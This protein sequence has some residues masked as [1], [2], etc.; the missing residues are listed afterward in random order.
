M[1]RCPE[2]IRCS[3]EGNGLFWQRQCGA[4]D[5]TGTGEQKVMNV[6][7]LKQIN[8]RRM[9]KVPAFW[10]T[11]MLLLAGWGIHTQLRAEDE[12]LKLSGTWNILL[13]G[14]DRRSDNWNGNSDTMILI[15]TNHDVQKIFMVSFMRDLYANIPGYGAQ[16]LTNAYA[17]GGSSLLA[18]TLESNFGVTVDNCLAADFVQVEAVLDL[19]GGVDVDVTDAEASVAND[20]ITMLCLEQNL[21]AGDYYI[22][23]GGVRHLNG[24]QALGYMRNRFV[25]DNDYERT[26]RQREV[27]QAVL[28]NLKS[29]DV[30]EL[31][32][33]AKETLDIVVDDLSAIDILKL[34]AQ[35]GAARKYTLVTDRIPYDGLYHNQ[36]EMLV[37]EQPATNERLA[38]TIYAAE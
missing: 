1:N 19:F 30:S 15:T 11:L 2:V 37:P 29:T 6:S 20:Y 38:S 14:S 13:I 26:Q 25:G 27:L 8:S 3:N 10:L 28:G 35:L 7:C 22:T 34:G 4:A 31:V 9:A 17:V 32:R 33:M 5:S 24:V 18:Q 16:K 36:G 12:S 23:G 21:N